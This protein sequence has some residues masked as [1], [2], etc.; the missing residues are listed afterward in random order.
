MDP[1][2]K[3]QQVIKYQGIIIFCKIYCYKIRHELTMS[4]EE[5]VRKE[6][7]EESKIMKVTVSPVFYK[8]FS[9]IMAEMY[10]LCL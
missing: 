10:T 1:V 5:E 6:I 3:K 9:A 8:V 2:K 7:K 4:N